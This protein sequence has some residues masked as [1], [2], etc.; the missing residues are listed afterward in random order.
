MLLGNRK[1]KRERE[2]E[3]KRKMRGEN[4]LCFPL[5]Y[6][7][8]TSVFARIVEGLKNELSSA[9]TMIFYSGEH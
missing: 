6:F 2:K 8:R 4:G 3:K 5:G 9:L 7:T 1:R